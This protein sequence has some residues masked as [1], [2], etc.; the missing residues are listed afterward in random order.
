MVQG[1]YIDATDE[2]GVPALYYAAYRGDI[3]NVQLLVERGVNL[4]TCSGVIGTPLSIAALKRHTAIVKILLHHGADVSAQGYG[5]GS[6]MHCAFFGGAI[7]IAEIFGEAVDCGKIATIPKSAVCLDTL[8]LLA[9]TLTPFQMLRRLESRKPR[10][11]GRKA[12]CVPALLAAERCYFGLLQEY[13]G[14]CYYKKAIQEVTWEA[15]DDNTVDELEIEF[16]GASLN[17]KAA[18]R[19]SEEPAYDSKASNSSAWSSLGF[20]LLPEHETASDPTLLMWAAATLNATLIEKLLEVDVEVGIEDKMGRTAI[21]YAALPFADA[22]FDDVELCFRSLT[23]G[24]AGITY[25]TAME[26]LRLTV[27][28]HHGALDPRISYRW[29][30]DIHSRC[31]AAIL[32]LIEPSGRRESS[33][34]ALQSLVLNHLC[35]TS[36][37]DLLCDNAKGVE[38][39][40]IQSWENAYYLETAL[41][42]AVGCSTAGSV[43]STLLDY[44]ADP[45]FNPGHFMQQEWRTPLICAIDAAAPKDV[46]AILLQ[47][48]ADP[49]LRCQTTAATPCELAKR[50][51]RFDMLQLFAGVAHAPGVDECPADS[52]DDVPIPSP[53]QDGAKSSLHKVLHQGI[54]QSSQVKTSSWCPNFAILPLSR[55]RRDNGST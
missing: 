16:S 14:K 15:L 17:T 25:E 9:E 11:S 19:V 7:D 43:V 1:A 41:V 54:G 27:S 38:G 46:V 21:H 36:S 23:K 34:D 51:R 13:F 29:G 52:T 6:A 49:Q 40:Q 26:L 50:S 4:N 39:E 20:P 22:T 33:R 3:Q 30:T 8:S 55:F 35:P 48:G 42:T 53:L 24:S 47:C 28:V 37:V 10:L 44:G 45:N 5:W 32:S 18:K 12:K 31:I 2:Y